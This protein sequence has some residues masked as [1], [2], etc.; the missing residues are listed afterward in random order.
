MEVK[1]ERDPMLRKVL[2]PGILPEVY[3]FIVVMVCVCVCVCVCMYVCMYVC[4]FQKWEA[5]ET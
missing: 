2:E 4:V 5:R 1:K 3:G